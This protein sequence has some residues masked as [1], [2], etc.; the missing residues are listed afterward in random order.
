MVWVVFIAKLWASNKNIVNIKNL[1]IL[2]KIK[3]QIIYI[4]TTNNLL[5][6]VTQSKIWYNGI[7]KCFI[8][9]M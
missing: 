1:K 8:Q 2:N 4:K 5:R 9:M 7:L 3:Y 6:Q